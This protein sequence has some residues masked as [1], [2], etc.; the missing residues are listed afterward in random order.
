MSH[1]K[2]RCPKCGISRP[3]DMSAEPCLG[4]GSPLDVAYTA[5]DEDGLTMPSP[6][7]RPTL[8]VTLG[9]GDTPSIQLTTLYARLPKLYAKLEFLNPTGSFKDRGTATMLSVAAEHGVTELVEDSSGNAGASVSAYAARA[10]IKSHIFVPAGAPEAKLRQIEA[11]GTEAQPIEGP[12]EAVTEAAI[13]YAEQR[14]LV[15]ASHMLSPYFAE[16]TKAF[17][18][19]VA[20]QFS[21]SMPGQVVFPVGNGSLLIGAYNGFRELK[22]SGQIENIPRLHAV[23]SRNVM[24]LVAAF[25]GEE[26]EP[27][28]ATKTVAGGISIAAPSRQ[29]QILDILRSTGGSAVAVE[30]SRILRVQKSL[31]EEEGIFAEPTSAVAFAG[32]EILIDQGAIQE[33]DTVL[34]PVTGFGLKDEL[35]GLPLEEK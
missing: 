24:P 14:G 23:Q 22:A 18:Y 3:A 29:W 34:V 20:Q 10:G 32:L 28:S 26:W 6:V 19:E 21:G 1:I 5:H 15:Y 2:L 9:E 35:P 27:E 17:A 8:D 4:C 16:G 25:N 33:S 11:Y 12:R 30:E 7:H 13:A 31:A